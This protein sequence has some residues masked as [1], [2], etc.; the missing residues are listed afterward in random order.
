MNRSLC[1]KTN[2]LSWIFTVLAHWNNS[3][4]ID[5]SLHS[6]TLSWF[7]LSVTCGRSV[8]SCSRHDIAKNYWVGVK[9]QSHTHL[10]RYLRFMH[11]MW[12]VPGHDLKK[13]KIVNVQFVSIHRLLN[14]WNKLEVFI[15]IIMVDVPPVVCRRYHV[16]FTLFVFVY[17]EWFQTHIVVWGLLVFL[18]CMVMSNTYFVL[19]VFVLCLV[20][21]MLPQCLSIVLKP[22]YVNKHK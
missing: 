10:I 20:Y 6:D 11:Q 8:V 1:T 2:T 16:L 18:L 14:T 9:Q 13:R 17:V 19:F 4:R 3:P 12:S 21:P 15:I 7:N 22:L 5:M